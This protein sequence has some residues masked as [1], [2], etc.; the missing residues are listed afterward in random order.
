MA[1]VYTRRHDE[2]RRFVPK[3][4]AYTDH[5]RLLDRKDIDAVI[6]A[7]L[8]F[9]HEIHFTDTIK[10]KD[11]YSEKT[12]TWSVP[13]AMKCRDLAKNSDRVIQIGLHDGANDSQCGTEAPGATS[14]PD[15]SGASSVERRSPQHLGNPGPCRPDPHPNQAPRGH[16]SAD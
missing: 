3:V 2:V 13:E 9:L 10:G 4:E 6:V 8:V 14:D 16:G 11:L 1:D 12:M 5:H 7:K 15:A